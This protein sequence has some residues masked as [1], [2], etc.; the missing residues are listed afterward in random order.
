MQIVPLAG[1]R[2]CQS[3]IRASQA[4]VIISLYWPTRIFTA[5]IKSSVFKNFP[6]SRHL[7]WYIKQSQLSA[8]EFCCCFKLMPRFWSF[9]RCVLA[10]KN[11]AVI[12]WWA[13]PSF[14]QLLVRPRVAHSAPPRVP[15]C[16]TPAG[17]DEWRQQLSRGR[18]SCRKDL[19]SLFA[20]ASTTHEKDIDP[21]SGQSWWWNHNI[22]AASLLAPRP[23]YIHV[24]F[25]IT[26]G[27]YLE[28]NE[29]LSS[30]FAWQIHQISRPGL[31]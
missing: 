17:F 1:K 18:I 2:G 13:G 19:F 28:T 5:A 7:F 31:S 21:L 30:C 15:S 26:R 11:R 25:I 20:N 23:S 10:G 12:Q 16:R 14:K 22:L 24:V 9:C 6:K 3:F 29:A 4:L 8:V 27:D